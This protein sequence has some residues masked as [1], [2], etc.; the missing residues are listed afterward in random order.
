MRGGGWGL[1]RSA[2]HAEQVAL[3]IREAGGRTAAAAAEGADYPALE[4]ACRAL[5]EQ[6]GGS[7]DVLVNNAGLN[8][9]PVQIA[10]LTPDLDVCFLDAH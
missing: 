6:L 4:V 5:Q 7:F 10:A 1:D 8:D 3:Q 9:G 2:P